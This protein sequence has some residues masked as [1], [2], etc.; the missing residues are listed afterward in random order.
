MSDAVRSAIIKTDIQYTSRHYAMNRRDFLRHGMAA[1]GAALAPFPLLA[2]TDLDRA[3]TFLSYS[4]PGLDGEPVPLS[5]FQGRPLVVN[6]WATWCAPCIKE[7]PDLDELAHKYPGMTFL[8]VAIDTRP[9][10]ERFLEKVKV[11]YPL[12]VAGHGGIQQMK[13]L[14][15]SKGG[16]PYT[17][18]FDADSRISHEILGQVD[19]AELDAHLASLSTDRG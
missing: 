9:N 12:V 3:A 19:P 13:A 11:S 1:A 15:N 16:L 14:G 17:V 8:G 10:I 18:V 6:F 2:G 4:Y 5:K 7:M